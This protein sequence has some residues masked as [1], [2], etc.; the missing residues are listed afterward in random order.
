MGVP[1][2]ELGGEKKTVR[3]GATKV[4]YKRELINMSYINMS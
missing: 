4:D 2:H 1:S 3:E